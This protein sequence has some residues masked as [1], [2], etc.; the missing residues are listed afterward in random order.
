[1]DEH[2]RE[3]RPKSGGPLEREDCQAG[4]EHAKSQEALRGEMPIHELRAEEHRREGREV[5][6]SQDEG[7]LP[8]RVETQA[9]Q[10]KRHGRK[11]RAPD[12]DIQKHHHR[13]LGA[14]AAHSAS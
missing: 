11:P 8:V 5:K 13:E 2:Q 1:M 4:D 14:V 7:L 12:E 6:C 10:V 3:E 9:L